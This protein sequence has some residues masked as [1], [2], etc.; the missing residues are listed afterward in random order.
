MCTVAGK[1][2]RFPFEKLL[3]AS[4]KPFTRT[5]GAWGP[6]PPFVFLFTISE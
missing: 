6:A 2:A 3:A 4:R 1:G 5:S